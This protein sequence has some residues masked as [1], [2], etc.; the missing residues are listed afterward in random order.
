MNMINESDETE[1]IEDAR[2]QECTTLPVEDRS[3]PAGQVLTQQ[4][5]QENHPALFVP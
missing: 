3:L 4:S 2:I 1:K 5:E